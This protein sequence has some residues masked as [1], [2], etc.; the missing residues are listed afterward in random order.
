MSLCTRADVEAVLGGVDLTAKNTQ[1]T[2]LISLIQGEMEGP[3]GADRPLE[4]ADHTQ[5]FDGATSRSLWLDHTPVNSVT[6]VTEDGTALTENDDWLVYP[7]LGRILRISGGYRIRWSTTKPRSIVVT[8]NGGYQAAAI[9]DDLRKACAQA[10]ADMFQAGAAF[11]SVPTG[12]EHVES[13]QMGDYQITYRDSART[14][15]VDLARTQAAAAA[16]AYRRPVVA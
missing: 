13:E 6:S 7:E 9:P 8:Y 4:A 14:V 15:T 16:A 5:T 2:T 12:D 10:V 3:H 11:A 1:I